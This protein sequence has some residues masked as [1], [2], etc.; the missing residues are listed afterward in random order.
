MEKLVRFSISLEIDLSK[1][2]DLWMKKNGYQNRSEA[3]RDLIRDKLVEEE[4]KDDQKEVVAILSLV[5]DHGNRELPEVLTNIQHEHYNLIMSSTHIHLDRD[6]C[7]EAIILKG[8]AGQ[9]KKAASKLLSLRRVKH[10]R[11]LM[12]TTGRDIP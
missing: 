2:F 3:I 8:K 6:N 12:S 11:L 1:K 9:I 7:L 4:W 10:G 5:Y